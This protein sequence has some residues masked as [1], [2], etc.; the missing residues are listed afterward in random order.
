MSSKIGA[1]L[2]NFYPYKTVTKNK[3]RMST[4]WEKGWKSVRFTLISNL[5]VLVSWYK[6]GW[7]LSLYLLTLSYYF[8]RWTTAGFQD[9]SL[10]S[11]LT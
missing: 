9:S 8:P 4:N 6:F 10:V 3:M 2:N 7:L 5:I 11:R 1:F